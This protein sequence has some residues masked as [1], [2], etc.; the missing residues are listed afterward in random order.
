MTVALAALAAA[1]PAR[2]ATITVTD[3]PD[4][5]T[6]T[7]AAS[8]CKTLRAALKLAASLPGADTI[9]LPRTSGNQPYQV[10]AGE[11]LLDSAV[12]I[13]GVSAAT[14]VRSNAESRVFN[15]TTTQPVTITHLTLYNGAALSASGGNMLIGQGANVTLDHVR[16]TEG[17]ANRGGGIAMQGGSN[18]TISQSL[19]D[20]NQ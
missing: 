9:T 14:S 18:V 20:G 15:V 8:P 7:C 19:I 6:D 2:A 5:A 4:S 3:I 17:N 1:G 11:L 16:V 13:R 12:T 10:S